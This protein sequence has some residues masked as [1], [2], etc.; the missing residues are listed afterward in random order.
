M[1]VS[2]TPREPIICHGVIHGQTITLDSLPPGLAEGQRVELQVTSTPTRKP[3]DGLR[4]AFGAWA[5]AGPEFD[6]W[7]RDVYERRRSRPTD[8]ES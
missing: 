3:G 7:L 1:S 6:E 5:D 2:D 8:N 4:A